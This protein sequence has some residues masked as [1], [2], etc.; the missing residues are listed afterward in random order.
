MGSYTSVQQC[1]EHYGVA[2]NCSVV[3]APDNKT[4]ISVGGNKPG[5]FNPDP[6]IAGIGILGAF[7]VI[8]GFA[9]LIAFLHVL[10]HYAKLIKLK[11]RLTDEEKQ[12]KKWQLSIGGFFEMLIISC[13]DQQIFTGAAYAITMRFAKACSISAY[14]Y[15]VISNML[16]LTCATHLL[17]LLVSKHYWEHPWVAGIRTVATALLYLATGILLSTQA[18]PGSE[19]AFPTQV[20]KDDEK[21]STLLLPAACFQGSAAQFGNT[22]QQSFHGAGLFKVGDR[23]TGWTPFVILVLFYVLANIVTL[24]RVV[25]AGRENGGR[26]EKFCK[27]FV[28]LAGTKKLKWVHRIGGQVYGV[29]LLAGLAISGYTMASSSEYIAMLRRWV[30]RSGWIQLFDGYNSENDPKSFGQLVPLLMITLTVF[31]FLQM[32]SEA[33]TIRKL[34]NNQRDELEDV[35]QDFEDQLEEARASS[36]K[37][38]DSGLGN[39]KRPEAQKETFSRQSE[40][41]GSQAYGTNSQTPLSPAPMYTMF[42][43]PSSSSGAPFFVYA[44]PPGSPMATPDWASMTPQQGTPMHFII[45]AQFVS[46]AFG[47]TSPA[48]GSAPPSQGFPWNPPTPFGPAPASNAPGSSKPSPSDDS[49]S[50]PEPSAKAEPEITN[51]TK[52]TPVVSVYDVNVTPSPPS[53]CSTVP[54][55]RPDA[56]DNEKLTPHPADLRRAD[57]DFTLIGQPSSSLDAGGQTGQQTSGQGF[58]GVAADPNTLSYFPA[59]AIAE[60]SVEEEGQAAERRAGEGDTAGGTGS[61]VGKAM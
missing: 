59:V 1:L 43:N 17:T 45:P 10:W 49:S 23:I 54:V 36:I 30:D 28:E 55:T 38:Q 53:R 58:G 52:P 37:V 7:V 27:W 22:L 33:I 40:A 2:I 35:R 20:P 14:H 26:R 31:T 25:R 18:A 21:W 5:E 47:M 57:T 29:Y 56:S 16:L 24:G 4:V 13:S 50:Q 61:E 9:L 42:A 6:D 8:T 44:A 32:L 46:G 19:L 11:K 39:G 48:N 60:S 3:Y 41:S 34:K 15:N 51:D 12:N